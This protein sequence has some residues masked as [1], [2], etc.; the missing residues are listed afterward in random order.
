MINLLMFMI[1]ILKIIL[2]TNY[3]FYDKFVLSC[4]DHSTQN[5]ITLKKKCNNLKNKEKNRKV[6]WISQ[7]ELI[8]TCVSEIR[9]K[10]IIRY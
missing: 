7:S 2:I 1:I 3:D 8:N 6:F 4:H 5:N 10:V 9:I